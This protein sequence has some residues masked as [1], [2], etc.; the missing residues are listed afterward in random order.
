M[1]PECDLETFTRLRNFGAGVCR[2]KRWPDDEDPYAWGCRNETLLL[3]ETIHSPAK[4]EIGEEYHKGPFNEL[5][6]PIDYSYNGSRLRI[7]DEGGEEQLLFVLHSI[8]RRV[9]AVAF[10]FLIQLWRRSPGYSSHPDYHVVFDAL[11]DF[12]VQQFPTSDRLK[13][14]DIGTIVPR[15][16]YPTDKFEVFKPLMVA[17]V[18]RTGFAEKTHVANEDGCKTADEVLSSVLDSNADCDTIRLFKKFGLRNDWQSAAVGRV[19][20]VKI[21]CTPSYQSLIHPDVPHCFS[22]RQPDGLIHVDMG[23]LEVFPSSGNQ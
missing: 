5:L 7:G 19:V 4:W 1:E 16:F 14:H 18:L 10:V 17:T 6:R 23:V 12:S 2:V 8:L 3:D 11:H 22:L 13:S 9:T 20:Q 15:S 21:F